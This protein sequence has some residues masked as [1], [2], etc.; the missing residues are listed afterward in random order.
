MVDDGRLEQATE[1]AQ[2]EKTERE[3]GQSSAEQE[4]GERRK[5]GNRREIDDDDDDGGDYNHVDARKNH[6]RK[7][8]ERMKRT[9]QD[10]MEHNEPKI[11]IAAVAMAT[12]NLIPTLITFVLLQFMARRRY[13]IVI[14]AA[15]AAA[16]AAAGAGH[17]LI[18]GRGSLRGR[19]S[20]GR[21]HSLLRVKC[22][23]TFI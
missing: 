7:L 23:A 15:A 10:K 22:A 6:R 1:K 20:T 9:N 12:E 11:A 17:W 18:G 5:S 13:A 8:H 16:A 2:R 14:C 3:A 21:R 19:S 4:N